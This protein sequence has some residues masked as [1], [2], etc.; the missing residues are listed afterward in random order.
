MKIKK[1]IECWIFD[2]YQKKFLLLHCPETLRHRP[3]WQ[4]VTGGIE[5]GETPFQSCLREIREE[6]G[7]AFEKDNLVRLFNNYSVSIPEDDMELN[8]NIFIVKTTGFDVRIST[9][10]TDY[11]WV[12][13]EQVRS[14]LLWESNKITFQEVAKYLGLS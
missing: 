6:T 7:K 14:M 4:P 5:N 3:Y 8:K 10:H 11:K 12:S 2:T 9:E 1:S 13:P